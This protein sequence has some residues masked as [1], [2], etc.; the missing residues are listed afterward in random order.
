LAKVKVHER[1]RSM[2]WAVDMRLS[3]NL[4]CEKDYF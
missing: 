4:R 1:V 3:L 2:A